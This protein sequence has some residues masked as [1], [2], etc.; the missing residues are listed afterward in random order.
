VEVGGMSAIRKISLWEDERLTLASA[1]ALTKA[2]LMGYGAKYRHWA[3]AFSGGKDSSTVA[4]LVVHLIATGQVPAPESLTILYSDTRMELPPLHASALHMLSSFRQRGIT[5]QIVV[6]PLDDRFFVYMFGRGV[7]PPKNRFRWCTP[8]LKVEP[9]LAALQD[10]RDQ[11]DEKILMLTGVRAGESAARDQRIALSCGKNGA[12]CG[13]GWFQET[14]PTAIADT[15]APILHWRVCHVWDWL[16]FHAPQHG[17]PTELIAESY[18]GDDALEIQARTGCVGCNLASKDVALDTLLKRYPHWWYLAP[19][20][21][22]RPL[23]AELIRPQHR[24][25]KD[26][27]ETRKDGSLVKNPMRM[28]PL[29]FDARRSGLAQVL[30]I[31]SEVNRSAAQADRPQ[32]DLINAE[33]QARIEE[34]IAAHTWPHGWHGDEVRADVM[35]PQVQTDGTIQHLLMESLEGRAS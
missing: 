16:T 3:I 26:G 22:L 10:L 12:E 35:L 2:S 34:L 25:R 28:G 13:Q 15:L 6:P 27:S 5:T 29:T 33:E 1:L 20:K 17:F 18:G 9:M 19:L 31:Q 24:L 11:S 7:P 30:A 4:T 23:Y 21:R 14:T 32:I 8:Q